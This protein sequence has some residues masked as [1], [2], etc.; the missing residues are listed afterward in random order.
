MPW[1]VG[2]QGSHGCDGYPV[3]KD[4][5]DEVEGCHDTRE[6][7]NRQL[8]A[9]YANEPEAGRAELKAKTI[10]D[11][12]DS[13]FAYIEPGGKKDDQGKTVPRSK[14]HFPIH[15]AAHVRNALARA[16]Q[17]PFGDKAM[18]KIRAAAKKMGIGEPAEKARSDGFAGPQ[19]FIRSYPLEDIRILT[20][21]QGAEY[22][23][24]RTVEALVA[25]WDRE[26]EIHDGQ[27]NYLETIG[28]TAFDKAIM[29]A[30]PQGSRTAWRTGVFYN[31]GLSLHGTPS[32][33]FSVPLGSP[34]D[35]RAD[36][37]G[38]V[39]VTRYN[40]TPLADE[41]LET[42]RSGDI[43]GHS[44]TGRIIKSN[45][46]R[47]PRGGYRRGSRGELTTV[48]RMELG[49]R[50]YGPTPFPAYADTAVVSVRSLLPFMSI[51]QQQMVDELVEEGLDPDETARAVA[52]EP[53]DIDTPPEDGGAVTDEPPEG[54]SSRES[55]LQRIAV[56]KTTRPGLARNPGDEIRRTRAAEIA[57][58]QKGP[59]PK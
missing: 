4:G 12:P 45:P 49:L 36:N 56:A 42:I 10:N 39:T 48:H 23:D 6:Q 29:D 14:R 44:F 41:I 20:R 18:P 24:G 22:S 53:V 9:L 31:H 38:L 57:T 40:E 21:A 27:G 1:H 26:A 34:V 54:H 59:G 33:R 30:R 47:P 7:A 51:T 25:V 2:E 13:A 37:L 16:P 19:L 17:S 5:T 52:E 3:I 50:E 46:A 28:R 35:I 43:T 8:A 32:D 11:L 58:G 15:D 55:L